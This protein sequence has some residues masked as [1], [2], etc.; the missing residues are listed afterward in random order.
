MNET[1]ID[2]INAKMKNTISYDTNESKESRVGLNN[3]NSRIRYFYGN[4]YG[5]SFSIDDTHKLSCHILL[6]N[7]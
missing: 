2:A 6:G 7:S 4:N 5:I 3:V 1:Q